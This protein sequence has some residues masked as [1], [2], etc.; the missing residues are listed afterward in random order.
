MIFLHISDDSNGCSFYSRYISETFQ[1]NVNL[2]TGSRHRI[3]CDFSFDNRFMHSH[4][5]LTVELGKSCKRL[6]MQFW[7]HHLISRNGSCS[8]Q[9]PLEEHGFPRLF[10]TGR[11]LCF[12]GCLVAVH[13]RSST[14]C[15]SM[16]A[17]SPRYSKVSERVS[18][19]YTDKVQFTI[20]FRTPHRN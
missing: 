11:T 17:V 7:K 14:I 1:N 18:Y 16:I 20:K 9:Y 13:S 4:G 12:V 5:L 15:D 2:C 10:I 6:E 3:S 19:P 8:T